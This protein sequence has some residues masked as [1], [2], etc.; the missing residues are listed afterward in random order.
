M[1][2]QEN[3]PTPFQ[4]FLT[5]SINFRPLCADLLPPAPHPPAMSRRSPY[6]RIAS[7]QNP[8]RSLKNCTTDA[9]PNQ[10]SAS[11][12]FGTASVAQK[13]TYNVVPF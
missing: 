12:H 13:P 11:S 3:H 7:V 10:Y 6:L 1:H 9:L 8:W 2:V 5:M 4:L